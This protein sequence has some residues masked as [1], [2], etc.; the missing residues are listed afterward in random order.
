MSGSHLLLGVM[1][2][3]PREEPPF[4]LHFYWKF[5]KLK[6]TVHQNLLP[7]KILGFR[8]GISAVQIPPLSFSSSM[9]EWI[10]YETPP[11]HSRPYRHLSILIN[12]FKT[13]VA[14][15]PTSRSTS[16]LFL[17]MFYAL[18]IQW[19]IQM[20]GLAWE[21]GIFYVYYLS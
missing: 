4:F 8:G 20:D 16:F 21:V 18:G 7:K 1:L 5:Q 15:P 10:F 3:T 19:R 12:T 17:I 6:S 2:R 11:V 14:C 13:G 9:I